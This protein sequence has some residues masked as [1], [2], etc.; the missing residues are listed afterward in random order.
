MIA[1]VLLQIAVGDLIVQRCPRLELASHRHAPLSRAAIHLPDADGEIVQSVLPG[2]PV[3]I[4][5]GYRGGDTGEWTG[6]VQGTR[7]VN[8]DQLC[9]LAD[10]P[11]LP[12]VTTTVRECYADE[13]AMA[14]ARHILDHAG[15]PVARLDI[16]DEIIPHFPLSTV[17]CCMAVRQLLHT[18]QRI[19]HDMRRTA[20][21]LGRDG[22]NLGDFDEPGAIPVIESEGN[23]IRHQP[24]ESR[25]GLHQLE[26][27]LLP[28]LS[29]SRRFRLTDTRLGTDR[30][31]R[32]LGV[33][34]V[35]EPDRMR[36]F[37]GY[38]RELGC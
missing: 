11:D 16:P 3:N 6:T 12:L 14:I 24:S 13:S 26:T 4:R 7:R 15:L 21:W 23:L 35:I 22:L 10:G 28:G 27:F 18:L 29:H 1:G 5:Y 20:L 34:H 25:K 32:A 36:T 8:R 19:G 31:F 37:I 2:D 38:G 17:P 30:T 33:R 9:I